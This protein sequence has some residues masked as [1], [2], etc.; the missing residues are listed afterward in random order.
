VKDAQGLVL[1]Q[2]LQEVATESGGYVLASAPFRRRGR[3]G[4]LSPTQVHGWWPMRRPG[5]SFASFGGGSVL[6]WSPFN[7]G[8]ISSEQRGVELNKIAEP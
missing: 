4:C 3:F 2:D 8:G 5:R 1:N 7:G 6:P